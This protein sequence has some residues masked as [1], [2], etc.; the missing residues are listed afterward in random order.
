MKKNNK[1]FVLVETLVVTVFVAAV[2]SVIYIN[3]Y[4][5]AGEYERREFYDDIDSKYGAYWLK[6]FIQRPSYG[7]DTSTIQNK[8]Y[9]KFECARLNNER[10]RNVCDAMYQRLHVK[11]AIISYYQLSD[12]TV[13]TNPAQND[14]LNYKGLKTKAPSDGTLKNQPSL[15]SYIE[16]LPKYEVKSLNGAQYRVIVEFERSGDLVE[17]EDPVLTYA[18]MEVIK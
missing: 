18:T 1:G 9:V 11:Q 13:E 6:V 14:G 17:E 16:Y 5:L 4:P 15:L 2:F 3:F 12:N 10:D 8:G 7:L